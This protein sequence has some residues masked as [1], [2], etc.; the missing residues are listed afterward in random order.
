MCSEAENLE[1][2]ATVD[3]K[4]PMV[5]GRRAGV[6]VRLRMLDL[7]PNDFLLLG[8]KGLTE[9]VRDNVIGSTLSAIP[10]PQRACEAPACGGGE[11]HSSPR[12]DSRDCAFRLG[13]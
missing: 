10:D 6:H 4:T 9:H 13:A 8:T 11:S 12:Y 3:G 7:E 5:G 1:Q 2:A